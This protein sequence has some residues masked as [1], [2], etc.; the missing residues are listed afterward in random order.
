MKNIQV[1][2]ILVLLLGL[3][4]CLSTVQ[5]IFTEKDLVFDNRLL[6]TWQ[7][8]NETSRITVQISKAQP[9]DFG[10]NLALRKLQG[11]TYAFRYPATDDSP[12]ITYL[13][14]LVKLGNSY[15]MDY[16]PADMP[17]QVDRFYAAHYSKMHTCFRLELQ[18]NNSFALKQF[19][20][21]YLQK[22]I[23]NKKVRISHE[24][25]RDQFIITASTEELQQYLVKYS[26]VPEAYYQTTTYTRV[27]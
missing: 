22:L 7:K 18:S 10:E 2:A 24:K 9:A 1:L 5:P 17:L 20:D 6:G 21:T 11:K 16:F 8:D 23:E 19:S 25:R 12:G 26:N 27:N 15:Y 13:G 14:F 3:T 4:S